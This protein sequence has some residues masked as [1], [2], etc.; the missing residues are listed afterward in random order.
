VTL[1]S[2]AAL[3]APNSVQVD[4]FANDVEV[5]SDK[6]EIRVTTTIPESSSFKFVD[7]LVGNDRE[8]QNG[9]RFGGRFRCGNL[10]C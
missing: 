7:G 8:W 3:V 2:V 4:R 6:R 1:S 9:I 5:G 10:F